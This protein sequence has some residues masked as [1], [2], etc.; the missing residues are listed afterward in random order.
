MKYKILDKI[1]SDIMFE[2]YG[3][4][5]KELF[6]NAAEALFSVICEIKEVKPEDRIEVKVKGKDLKDLLYNWLE[7]LIGLVDIKEMFLSKFII[8]EI[9]DKELKAECYGEPLSKKKS[10][11][12]VKAVTYYKF[13]LDKTKQG[14]KA[15]VSLDI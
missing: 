8:K 7:N 4:N 9:S 15:L 2:V 1:T 13:D 3:K 11:T 6:S 12:V 14:Y 5:E 10:G